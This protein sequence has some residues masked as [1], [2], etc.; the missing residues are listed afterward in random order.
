MKRLKKIFF[1]KKAKKNEYFT[2]RDHFTI[3]EEE[4]GEGTTRSERRKAPS[5]R[6]TGHRRPG[7]RDWRCRQKTEGMIDF[8]VI[9]PKKEQMLAISFVLMI[10][11]G[12]GNK[13][14]SKL[15]VWKNMEVM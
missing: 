8:I 1:G 14:L 2:S 10:L 15:Q 9:C 6:S 3:K 4:N 11:I 5:I 7:Q 13:V 12:L